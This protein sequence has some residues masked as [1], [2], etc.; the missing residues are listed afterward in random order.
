MS[1]I[2]GLFAPAG[3]WVVRIIDLSADPDD[4]L[5]DQVKGF[6]SLMQAVEFARRYVR[7]SLERCR[8]P[9]A[10]PAEVV[11]AWM[12][13]GEDAIVEGSETSFQSSAEVGNWSRVIGDD[14][15]RDWRSLDPRRSG[16]V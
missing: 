2:A 7:D 15:S 9:G 16:K 4:N 6:P 11:A 5:L 12:E 10:E 13:F 3:G 14:E 1:E 8:L